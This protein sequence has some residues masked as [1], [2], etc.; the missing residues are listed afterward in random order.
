MTKALQKAFEAAC[1]LAAVA[2]AEDRAGRTKPLDDDRAF[3]EGLRR[4]P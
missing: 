1:R 2:L 4:S 3:P